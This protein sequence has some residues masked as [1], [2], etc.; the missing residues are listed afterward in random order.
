MA[1]ASSVVLGQLKHLR[2]EP[3]APAAG[4][5]AVADVAR[6]GAG[7]LMGEDVADMEGTEELSAV[8]DE[9]EEREGGQRDPSAI[10]EA[11]QRALPGNARDVRRHVLSYSADR[12]GPERRVVTQSVAL[13]QCL[14][15][16]G[17]EA[18]VW[19]GQTPLRH[20]AARSVVSGRLRRPARSMR[21]N[22]GRLH[23]R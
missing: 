20:G 19:G 18:L 6:D 7:V 3:L 4:T 14:Q 2:A 9:P 1:E 11:V 17:R 15:V 10:G 23:D 22:V 13:A 16:R 12:L 8:V 21:T 5:D